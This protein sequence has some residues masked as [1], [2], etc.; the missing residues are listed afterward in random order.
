MFNFNKYPQ[1]TWRAE[2]SGPSVYPMK[3]ISAML[4]FKGEESGLPVPTGTSYGKCGW[5]F[6]IHPKI[7]RALPDRL[8]VTFYSYSENQTYHGEF[9]LPYDEMVTLFQWGIDNKV[10]RASYLLAQFKIFVVG[11]APGGS[12]G[13]WISGPNE[14]REVFFGQAEKIDKSL[15]SVFEV[16][17]ESEQQAEQF[18]AE[19]FREDVGEVVFNDIQTN[20]VPFDIWQRYRK[21]YHWIIDGFNNTLLT[22]VRV[23]HING[24]R[25]K[26][27]EGADF[28]IARYMT[29]P[30]RIVFDS[31]G[32]YYELDLDDYETIV[33]FEQLD[34]IEGLT[35]E[36]KL[37]H[38]EMT[39]KLPRNQS[40]VRIYNTKLSIELKK[41]AF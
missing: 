2:K 7:K 35:E 30:S 39:P 26:L 20:G 21:P 19:V 13:V 36:E 38:I 12:V 40:T 34:A 23:T 18:R 1:Y 29:I 8:A 32:K 9:A 16:P 4:Y 5:G 25:T 24:E 27:K 33:A 10:K 3:M 28:T 14:Q 41:A 15:S 37:I 6:A 22:G 17:F 31:G 11:I